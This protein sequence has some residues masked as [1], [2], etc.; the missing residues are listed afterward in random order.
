MSVLSDRDIRKHLHSGELVITNL[1]DVQIGASSVDLTLG[2]KF[3]VFKNSDVTH[4][5]PE[6]YD[7]DKIMNSI[8]KVNEPF[9]IHPGE[10][11]LGATTEYIKIPDFLV[12]RLDGRSS[13]GRLGII[14]HSTAGSVHPGFEGQLTLEIANISKL[15][16]ALHPGIRICQITFQTLT[17]A[18]EKPYNKNPESKYNNQTGPLVSKIDMEKK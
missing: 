1:S 17:S 15:P 10:F 18:V 4:I 3:L 5:N 2:N 12:G 6:D 7:K 11:V 16:V 8:I 13:F 14:V 9:I